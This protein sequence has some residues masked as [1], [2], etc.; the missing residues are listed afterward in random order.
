MAELLTTRQVTELLKID[1]TT[2]YRMVESGQLPAI[3]VG[4]QWRFTREAIEQ[5]LAAPLSAT[6]PAEAA[7]QQTNGQ[8]P[9]HAPTGAAQR[10]QVSPS[11]LERSLSELLPLAAAQLIQDLTADALGVTIVITD[12]DGKPVTNVSNA[13]GLYQTLLADNAAVAHC[14]Q[15]WQH[16]AGRVT[17]APKFM[18]NQMGLLCARGLIR[19]G[20]ALKG[21]VFFGGI[22]PAQWPPDNA[23]VAEIAAHFQLP[24]HVLAPHMDEVYRLNQQQQTFVLSFVQRIADI[25]S[26]LLQDHGALYDQIAVLQEVVDSRQ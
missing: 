1:R 11:N 26:L 24:V 7:K 9:P 22:A 23:E 19:T 25:F 20:N 5:F 21:M 18:P 17:L 12:M 2:I 4:K 10:R 14:I 13:C 6:K 8:P 16:F 3:R 15:E